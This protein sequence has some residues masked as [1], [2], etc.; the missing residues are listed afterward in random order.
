MKIAYSRSL[1]YFD[2]ENNQVVKDTIE[3]VGVWSFIDRNNLTTELIEVMHANF[4]EVIGKVR[5]GFN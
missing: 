1:P 3:G 2:V 4:T 5:E